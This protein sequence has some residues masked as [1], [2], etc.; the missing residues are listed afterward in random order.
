MQQY[1]ITSTTGSVAPELPEPWDTPRGNHSGSGAGN[2]RP[3]GAGSAAVACHIV[4]S[5]KE[6]S[7]AALCTREGILQKVARVHGVSCPVGNGS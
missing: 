1:V 4:K 3:T 6:E 7:V 5:R 2:W